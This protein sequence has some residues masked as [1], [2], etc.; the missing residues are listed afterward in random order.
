MMRTKVYVDE[1]F[2][3]RYIGYL[4]DGKI[5]KDTGK[6]SDECVG[7][8]GDGKVYLEKL[9]SKDVLA[10]YDWEYFYFETRFDK[11]PVAYLKDGKIYRKEYPL[12]CIGLYEGPYNPACIAL[13]LCDF[14]KQETEVIH[15]VTIDYDENYS[16]TKKSLEENQDEDDMNVFFGIIAGVIILIIGGFVIKMILSSEIFWILVA[17]VIFFVTCV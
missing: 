1:V 12:H 4:E 14:P 13:L 11:E 6:F 15:P 9:L 10:L 8:Y 7:R 2:K 17:I 3:K 5:Y 16:N